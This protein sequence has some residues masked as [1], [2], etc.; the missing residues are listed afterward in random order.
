M[1]KVERKAAHLS[2][3]SLVY[4]EIR[5]SNTSWRRKSSYRKPIK[6]AIS[7]LIRRINKQTD[8][9]GLERTDFRSF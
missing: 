3:V 1:K 4:D 8:R 2:Y 5:N 9:N 7:K 6:R